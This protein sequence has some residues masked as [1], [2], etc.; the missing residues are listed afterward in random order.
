MGYFRGKN[1]KPKRGDIYYIANSKFY[2]TDPMNEAG[3]PGRADA[4]SKVENR[5]CRGRLSHY[6]G[7][8]PYA[9]THK[10]HL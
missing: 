10:Y 1:I 4:V 3:R 9:Y 8:A 6:E 5:G 2:A 7:Q